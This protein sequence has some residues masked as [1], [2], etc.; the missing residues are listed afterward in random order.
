MARFFTSTRQAMFLAVA[1]RVVPEMA[2]LDEAGRDEA[3]ALVERQLAG[4]PGKM[5]RELALFL[6]VIRWAPVLRYGRP[7]D[8]LPPGPRD[9]V[10]AWLEDAPVTKL[11]S[12]FWGL[13]TLAFLAYYG[14]PS[15]AETINYRPARDGNAL[16]HAR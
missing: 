3:L 15:V 6:T 4:R 14:R 12:G 16:L 8:R 11:R 10:L 5:R 7:F 9:A 13:K 2:A 1:V